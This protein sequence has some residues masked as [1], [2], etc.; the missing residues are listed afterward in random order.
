MTEFLAK[1]KELAGRERDR[2]KANDSR[3]CRNCHK[4]Q[5]MAGQ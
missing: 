4:F 1:R 5:Y 3:E 2:M